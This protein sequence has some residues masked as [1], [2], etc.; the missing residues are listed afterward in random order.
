MVY[1]EWIFYYINSKEFI[2]G[3]REHMT[4]TAGQQRLDINYVKNYPVVVPKLIEQRRILDNIATEKM[5][6]ESSKKLVDVFTHKK[7]D[8]INEIWGG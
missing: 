3:G 4:G 2:N 8:R 1:P 6:I 5:L 7:Q